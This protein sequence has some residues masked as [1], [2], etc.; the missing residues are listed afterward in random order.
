MHSQIFCLF[1]FVPGK[2]NLFLFPK[3]TKKREDTFIQSTYGGRGLHQAPTILKV[4]NETPLYFI[5]MSL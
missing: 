4:L 3:R 2:S 1:V 5:Q